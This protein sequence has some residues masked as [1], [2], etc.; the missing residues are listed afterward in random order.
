MT[1][2]ALLQDLGRFVRDFAQAVDDFCA[3]RLA[4]EFAAAEEE[5]EERQHDALAGERLGGGDADFRAGVEI[6]AGIGF[7][8]DGA[9]DDVDDAEANAP[10]SLAFA[11]GGEGVGGFAGLADG[12]DDGAFFDDAG[13]GSGIRWRR[14]LR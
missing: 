5:G 14:S 11:Q 4:H 9:A 12:D 10:F 8:G 3:L 6:D 2:V 7:A 1:S 13:C